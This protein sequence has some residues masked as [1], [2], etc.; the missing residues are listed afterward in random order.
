MAT[1]KD[2]KNKTNKSEWIDVSWPLRQGMTVLERD[3]VPDDIARYDPPTFEFIHPIGGV[4]ITG[5]KMLAHTGTHI[6]APRHCMPAGATIDNMPLDTIIGP[7][8]IIEIKD[9]V[10]IK[11]EELEYYDIQP[12]ERIL[13]KT[14]NSDKCYKK[15]GFIKDYVYISTEAAYFLRDKRILVVGIDYIVPGNYY[16]WE[17]NMIPVH[18]AF[19]GNGIWLIEG[20]NLSG[21]R[22][23]PYEVICLPLRLENGDAGPARCIV[24]AL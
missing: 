4:T 22:P 16:D 10:S 20:I 12:G 8:R 17:N 1:K 13:F 6:D 2:G 5:L 21:L 19:L 23:G 24:R 3:Y 14:Q 7:A 15:D 11:P 9:P 18:E